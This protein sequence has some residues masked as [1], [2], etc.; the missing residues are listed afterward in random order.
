M[1][2][3]CCSL[4]LIFLQSH[5][6]LISARRPFKLDSILVE[7]EYHKYHI[8]P[9]TSMWVM[10]SSYPIFRSVSVFN[11]SETLSLIRG[12]DSQSRERTEDASVPIFEIQNWVLTQP[13]VCEHDS[14]DCTKQRTPIYAREHIFREMRYCWDLTIYGT[15]TNSE[16]LGIFEIYR[17]FSCF[18]TEILFSISAT[19]SII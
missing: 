6:I 2:L 10:C 12:L 11:H 19:F 9:N 17:S 7:I 8:P 16:I 14:S 1:I 3:L 5:K 15:S 18:F 4:S 13:G